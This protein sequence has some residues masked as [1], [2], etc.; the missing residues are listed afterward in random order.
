MTRSSTTTIKAAGDGTPTGI[1]DAQPGQRPHGITRA[2]QDQV[3]FVTGLASSALYEADHLVKNI[4]DA[5]SAYK[6]TRDG[7]KPGGLDMT[8]I[9]GVLGEALDCT[10]L[11]SEHLSALSTDIRLHQGDDGP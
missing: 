11:A 3:Y 4:Q 10:D 6:A 8:H 9:L 5:A 2:R 1:A 7:D